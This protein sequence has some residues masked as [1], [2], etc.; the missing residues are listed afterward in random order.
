MDSEAIRVRAL[1]IGGMAGTLLFLPVAFILGEA[2]DGY[3]HLFQGISALSESGAPDA[4]AQTANFVV[5]GLLIAGLS[6]GLHKG[7]G[8]RRG[9]IVGPALIG[10]FGLLALVM[11]GIF[12][13]DPVG[14]PE[15]TVGTVHSTTAGFGFIFVIASMFILPRRLKG[16]DQWGAIASISPVFGVV[17]I[18]SMVT[19]LVAQESPLSILHPWTGLLQRLMAGAVFLWL[20]LLSVTLYRTAAAG[21]LGTD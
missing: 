19:Y 3:S 10:A 1:A 4:W 17:T 5:V 8:E 7:I 12:P 14:A 6:I 20:F 18:V 16:Q 2:R 21:M 13:A 15:T 11:N 9:S